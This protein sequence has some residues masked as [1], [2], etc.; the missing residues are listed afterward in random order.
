MEKKYLRVIGIIAVVLTVLML[1]YTMTAATTG[2]RAG[3]N[4]PPPVSQAA[5]KPVGQQVD[6]KL[7]PG[8]LAGMKRV[9]AVT[10]QNAID[11][12]SQMHGTDIKVVSAFVVMYQGSGKDQMTI[13][14]SES[15]DEK[16]AAAMFKAMDDKMPKTQYFQN[17]KTVKIDGKEYKFVTGK[18]RMEHY[19]WLKG[20]R[21]IWVGIA[22]ANTA[23]V[24]KKVA[25]LY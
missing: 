3:S 15:K 14:L 21:N 12:V 10:G 2:N 1:A 16:D 17:Y 23:E 22:G 13:W 9:D 25:P 18:D 24:L 19:Y 6:E 8:E 4:N 11:S 20:K 5:G 7:F